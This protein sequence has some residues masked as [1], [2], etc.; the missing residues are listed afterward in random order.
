MHVS[1]IFRCRRRLIVLVMLAGISVTWMYC[2]H[3][4]ISH[5]HALLV[6]YVMP[7]LPVNIQFDNIE[8][9]WHRLRPVIYMQ[10]VR[11]MNS[12]RKSSFYVHACM[13]DIDVL[14]SIQTHTMVLSAMRVQKF[15]LPHQ[16]SSQKKYIFDE[17]FFVTIFH[18]L[19]NH[20]AKNFQVKINT[21][22][23]GHGKYAVNALKIM[24]HNQD[25]FVN[26]NM[27]GKWHHIRTTRFVV[28][29]QLDKNAILNHR[30]I[31]GQ[32][33]VQTDRL[34]TDQLT[35]LHQLRA[36]MK[37]PYFQHAALS[38]KSWISFDHLNIVRFNG[39]AGL[40]TMN[41]DGHA[42]HWHASFYG[43]RRQ[44]RLS[45]ILFN[46]TFKDLFHTNKLP[47]IA[48]ACNTHLHTRSGQ[49]N[50]DTL[51]LLTPGIDNRFTL[52]INLF[53]HT[54]AVHIKLFN[55]FDIQDL[56]RVYTYLTWLPCQLTL[57]STIHLKGK[58]NGKF[59]WEGVWDQMS[60]R[61]KQKTA[62][63]R[64]DLQE[65]KINNTLQPLAVDIPRGVIYTDFDHYQLH[66]PSL[67]MGA[68]HL[69]G[70]QLNFRLTPHPNLFFQTQYHEQPFTLTVNDLGQQYHK[71]LIHAAVQG[72]LNF[73]KLLKHCQLNFPIHAEGNAVYQGD[74]YFNMNKAKWTFTGQSNL[75][76]LRTHIPGIYLKSKYDAV[77][78][79]WQLHY[80]H[81]HLLASI[82][83]AD[84]A[85]G[86]F[87][88]FKDDHQFHFLKGEV[89]IGSEKAVLP[90]TLGLTIN[91]QLLRVNVKH[92]LNVLK[93]FRI[94]RTEEKNNEFYNVPA[95]LKQLH[96][97]ITECDFFSSIVH[98]LDIVMHLSQQKIKAMIHSKEVIGEFTVL[99][100][101]A[102]AKLVAAFKKMHFSEPFPLHD[103]G[104]QANNLVSLPL[105]ES[106]LQIKD[107]HWGKFDFDTVMLSTSYR[108]QKFSVDQFT[109]THPNLS[110]RACG[111][112]D[113][114]A[115]DLHGNLNTYDLG[116]LLFHWN[117]TSKLQGGKGEGI[118]HITGKNLLSPQF[119]YAGYVDLHVS[120]GVL[121]ELPP[122]LQSSVKLGAWINALDLRKLWR[123]LFSDMDQP[124]STGGLAFN[125]LTGYLEF[126]NQYLTAKRLIIESDIAHIETNGQLDFN[127]RTYDIDLTINPYITSSLPVLI[128]AVGTPILG[129]AVFL[130]DKVLKPWMSRQMGH[131]Y[132]VAGHY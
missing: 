29:M 101:A 5:K 123:K 19:L 65:I 87:E 51:K 68:V 113:K 62:H 117:I 55:E 121:T 64:A 104:D 72:A 53:N 76:G 89:T 127:Q 16:L 47:A 102:H 36:I 21:L 14:K 74:L 6:A 42:H 111:D 32:L 119:H 13:L 30:N 33:Y 79:S 20:A 100:S 49:F 54:Q 99:T 98:Q 3:W 116:T 85:S 46:I 35:G 18:Q 7:K 122:H 91:A 77:S 131:V 67:Q 80:G 105:I 34:H 94:S 8:L 93:Q 69:K 125:D 128:G 15:V 96:I 52:K 22:T 37:Y 58:V 11:V 60:R 95:Y 63:V 17:R 97:Y 2:E 110:I 25:A 43:K 129:G 83:Y 1:S 41:H 81:D 126:R 24:I 23:W 88:F 120:N 112:M 57:F 66:M 124:A 50:I 86:M 45:S 26:I 90:K 109:L 4:W 84:Q 82:L 78:L 48:F 31:R 75:L 44:D 132:H 71:H 61:L 59:Y 118:F 38:L 56:T 39:V 107:F 106:N 73:E 10:G 114:D 92:M 9:R 12:R 27:I 115:W 108:Y 130:A 103:T 70:S 28:M 40:N